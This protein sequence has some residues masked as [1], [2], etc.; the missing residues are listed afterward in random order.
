M[1]DLCMVF[2]RSDFLTI[3]YVT[4]FYNI[5]QHMLELNTTEIFKKLLKSETVNWNDLLK[6]V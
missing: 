1:K 4:D 3:F 6:S 5:L 2:E